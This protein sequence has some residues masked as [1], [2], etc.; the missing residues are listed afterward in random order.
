MKRLFTLILAVLL[1]F[2]LLSA[3]AETKEKAKAAGQQ[4]NTTKELVS[5]MHYTG[6]GV[7]DGE[8]R[9]EETTAK[10]NWTETGATVEGYAEEDGERSEMQG[11]LRLDDKN[12]PAIFTKITSYDEGEPREVTYTFSYPKERQIKVS[13]DDS[14]MLYDFDEDGNVIREE[15]DSSIKCYEYDEKGN[16]TFYSIEYKDDSEGQTDRTVYT[17]DEDGK[18]VFAE[19]TDEN[20]ELTQYHYTCHTNGNI[21][22]ELSVKSTGVVNTRF[23]PYN[24]K[25]YSWSYGMQ[26]YGG[27]EFTVEK[28]A[29]G[30]ITKV[31]GINEYSG[32]TRTTTFQYDQN[33]NLLKAEES[34]GKTETWEYDDQNRPVKY[35]REYDTGKSTTTYQYDAQGRLVQETVKSGTYEEI[36]TREY[37][38]AGMTSK[39]TVKETNTEY[40]RTSEGTV[41]YQYVENAKCPIDEEWAQFFI[42]NLLNLFYY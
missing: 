34:E 9:E 6:I 18:L 15:S 35:V 20:G 41:E 39:K 8:T 32:N 24:S 7:Q 29:N 17:Y 36:Q 4:K 2:C 5:E 37:N 14:E 3:C 25:D 26:D 11:E 22:F 10:I 1:C 40:N 28:D 31:V 23:L 42:K 27:M 12:R 21:L 38:E 16:R 30:Y 19:K 13:G 33:G